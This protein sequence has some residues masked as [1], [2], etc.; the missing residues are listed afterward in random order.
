MER[1]VGEVFKFEGIVLKVIELYD[2]D[3]EGCHFQDTNCHNKKSIIGKCTSHCREDDREVMFIKV[4]EE[5]LNDNN[6]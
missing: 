2:P 4:E 3:C 5:K 1:K 6:K